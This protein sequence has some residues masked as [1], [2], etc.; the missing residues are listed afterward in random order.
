MEGG[1]ERENFI[2]GLNKLSVSLTLVHLGMERPA[3]DPLWLSSFKVFSC[4]AATAAAAVTIT[5][6]LSYTQYARNQAVVAI[7]AYF[8]FFTRGKPICLECTCKRVPL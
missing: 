1:G 4:A 8:F 6:H 5:T 2:K 7:S 3:L